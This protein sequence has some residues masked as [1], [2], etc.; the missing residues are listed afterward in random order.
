MQST[1][2]FL[3]RTRE[4]NNKIYACLFFTHL[5]NATVLCSSGCPRNCSVNRLSWNQ[6]FTC[7]CL[8]NVGTKS[9]YYNHQA[10]ATVLDKP[11]L[12]WAPQKSY[13]HI[14]LEILIVNFIERIGHEIFHLL[15]IHKDNSLDSNLN[16]I[17]PLCHSLSNLF[18]LS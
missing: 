2:F 7:L 1:S 10:C 13:D 9:M 17:S 5:S 8:L 16:L 18:S 6:R 12:F 4:W 11:A 14:S 15:W 3:T